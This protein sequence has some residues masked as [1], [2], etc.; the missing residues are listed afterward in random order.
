[1][2]LSLLSSSLLS[3][4]IGMVSI[5]FNGSGA[6]EIKRHPQIEVLLATRH[7]RLKLMNK[8]L[9]RANVEFLSLDG[10]GLR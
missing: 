2:S 6:D 1:M 5:K 9:N 7:N 10:R 8:V 4:L 3:P